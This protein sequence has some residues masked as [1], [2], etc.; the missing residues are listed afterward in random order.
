MRFWDDF[1]LQHH[2]A[3]YTSSQF[4]RSEGIWFYVPIL[5]L[6][7]FPWTPALFLKAEPAPGL[8]RVRLFAW[9]WMLSSLAFFSLSQSKL[10]GYILPAA[11]AFAILAG[12]ALAG[13]QRNRKRALLLFGGFHAVI[14]AALFIGAGMFEVPARPVYVISGAIAAVSAIALILLM[15]NQ[16]GKALLAGGGITVTGVLLTATV[17]F[18]ATTWNESRTL[19]AAIAPEM[20]R[21]RRLL[22]YNVYDFSLVFYTNARVE[23]THDGYFPTVTSD[24]DL[25]RYLRRHGSLRVVAVNEEL[26]WMQRARFWRIES[27][28]RGPVHSIVHLRLP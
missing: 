3:R 5:L 2:L 17:L 13:V 9:C 28:L 6:G 10:P 24:R 26:E 27:V 19:A 20:S 18:P 16:P 23:L 4:H 12:T 22:L 14:V 15:R 11:P 25:Y 21:D 8:P 1:F 7:A